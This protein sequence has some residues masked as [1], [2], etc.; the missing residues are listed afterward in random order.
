VFDF[1]TVRR[2]DLFQQNSTLSMLYAFC[3][4]FAMSTIFKKIID[5]E[6][7]ADIVYEDDTVLAFLDIHPIRKGHVLIIPKKEFVNIFDL[8]SETF[9]HMAKVAQRIAKIFLT[10]LNAAGA[11]IHMNNGHEAGQDIFHAHIHVIPRF[12]RSEAFSHNEHES[13]TEGESTRL[14]EK[15]QEALRS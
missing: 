3:Y 7:P 15:I 6:I 8:D 4:Y 10:T 13:F 14:A 5:K 2:S 11:N 1:T 12:E 9:A